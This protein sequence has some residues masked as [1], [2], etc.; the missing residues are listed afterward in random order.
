M[1]TKSGEL[2]AWRSKN[3]SLRFFPK[4]RL[5]WWGLSPKG[6]NAV[7]LGELQFGKTQLGEDF[8]RLWALA[9]WVLYKMTS[10]A[11]P[12]PAEQLIPGRQNLFKALLFV[13]ALLTSFYLAQGGVDLLHRVFSFS[14]AWARP[15]EIAARWTWVLTLATINC[16]IILGMAVLGH[17]AVHRVLFKGSIWNELWGGILSALALIP[18]YINRQ[19]HLTHHSYAHQPGADPENAMHDHAFWYAMTVGSFIGI[20]IHYRTFVFNLL[21]RLFD[22]R[23]TGRVLKDAVFVVAAGFVYIFLVP[24]MGVSARYSTIPTALLFPVVFAF[25]AI[26]DHYGVPAIVRPAVGVAPVY[27]VDAEAWHRNRDARQKEVSGWVV[28]TSPL[29]EWVWSHVNYHEVHHKYPYLSHR[30]L[31]TTFEATRHQVPYLVV[32]GYL[33]SFLGLRKRSYYGSRQ[34]VLQF[35]SN[36]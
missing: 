25:R 5:R 23:F 34:D 27:D 17:E 6:R 30:Y 12:T 14:N 4:R 33:R 13:G 29:L 24:H 8:Y 1:S 36:K 16:F 15:A 9:C 22:R 19:I 21:T 32:N 7:T 2:T 31:K 18:F 3:C 11:I 20:A 28:L 35:S 10:S 26:S